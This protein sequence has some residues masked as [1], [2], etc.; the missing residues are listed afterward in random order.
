MSFSLNIDMI[1]DVDG[2]Y[3]ILKNTINENELSEW[4][5]CFSVKHDGKVKK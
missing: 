3:V 5:K 4:L 2:C 1:A